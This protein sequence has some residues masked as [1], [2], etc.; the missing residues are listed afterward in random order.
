MP[1]FRLFTPNQLMIYRDHRVESRSYDTVS[2]FGMR[3]PELVGVF[4]QTKPFIR[5]CY[6]DEKII[7]DDI[8]ASLL[9]RDIR[10]CRWVSLLS[11]RVYIRINAVDEVDR[12]VDSNLA[13]LNS[14]DNMNGSRSQFYRQS[15]QAVKYIIRIYKSHRSDLDGDDLLFKDEYSNDFFYDDGLLLCPIPVP[16]N[17]HPKNAQVFFIHFLLTHGKYITELD[18]IHHS[19]PRDMLKSAQLIGRRS[20]EESL[21]Q[22]S[23]DLVQLYILNELTFLANSMRKTD[24]F[25]TLVQRLFDDII[26]RNEFSAN[27]HPHT[28]AGLQLSLTDEFCQFWIDNRRKQLQS[29]YKEYHNLEGIPVREQVENVTRSGFINWDPTNIP[30]YAEQSVESFEE[31]VFALKVLKSTIDKYLDSTSMTHT[32]GVIVHGG[33]GTGKT[34]I[35]KLAVLYA[36]SKGLNIISTSILGVR[37]SYLGGT[38]LHS[39]FCWTP[40]N[41]V[42]TPHKTAMSALS[43]IQRNPQSRHIILSLDALFIDEVGTLSN[44]Q[45]IVLDIMFRKHRGSPLPFGGVLIIGS[46]DPRQIGVIK[47]M[48]LLTS[49]LILTCIQAVKLSHSVRAH[50]DPQYQELLNIMRINPLDLID[51][52]DKKG[53][54]FN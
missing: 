34:H 52:E 11:Q 27:E 8:H 45:L 37:A 30:Q 28:I 18:V 44:Q 1:N 6:V 3:S 50:N 20:D 36:L 25:I 46:L 9:N 29:I 22:Y 43:R 14:Y 51:D 48:P 32:K 31:Q 39:L 42:S 33:P 26:I 17:V 7:P 49:T 53:G 23:T 16:I 5:C 12:L 15:N 40:Q 4:Q 19:S 24:I 54:S 21:K 13:Y 10:K 47:A 35:A 41:R 38:H 2:M